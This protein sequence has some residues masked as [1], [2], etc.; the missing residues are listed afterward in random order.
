[1]PASDASDTASPWMPRTL[2]T[3][4][5]CPASGWSTMPSTPVPTACTHFSLLA[6]PRILP[7][8]RCGPNVTSA[9]ASGT[10]ARPWQA[11]RRHRSAG[12]EIAP[13]ARL[14]DVAHVLWQ[15]QQDQ[16]ARHGCACMASSD[17][18][19]LSFILRSPSEARDSRMAQVTCSHGSTRRCT[20]L[21]TMRAGV[22]H[23]TSNTFFSV[24]AC[25]RSRHAPRP[26]SYRRSSPTWWSL[27]ARMHGKIMLPRSAWFRRRGS[28]AARPCRNSGCGVEPDLRLEPALLHVLI[29][30][31]GDVAAGG[32]GLHQ[33]KRVVLRLL[34]R[35]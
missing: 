31:I 28:S 12:Q 6:C 1:M 22:N 19:A 32:A 29:V 21:L 4:T 9:S 34:L 14:I 17:Q 24:C 18:R 25:S 35:L 2:V 13:H 26:C 10:T 3:M 8:R 16:Q 20:P 7:S 5:C 30:G 11:S 15:R 33:R 27:V 23:P